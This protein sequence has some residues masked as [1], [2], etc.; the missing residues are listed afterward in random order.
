MKLRL[1]STCLFLVLAA[2][3]AGHP[4]RV[5]GYRCADF[6]HAEVYYGRPAANRVAEVRGYPID[7]QYAVFICGVQH[8][9]PPAWDRAQPF[10]E[11]GTAAAE[12][13]ARRLPLASDPAE[14]ESIVSL[15][16]RMEARG[17]YRL[18]KDS[19]FERAL[20]LAVSGIRRQSQKE[21]VQEELD[22]LVGD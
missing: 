5:D 21:R 1:Q 22:R 17:Q 12:F 15:L 2:G 20:Q 6:V 3:C 13:L 11:R 19:D 10:A 8:M 7:K 18:T 4:V 14:I 9:R 16:L